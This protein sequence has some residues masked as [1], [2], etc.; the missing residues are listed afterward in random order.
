MIVA[1]GL[2]ISGVMKRALPTATT[3]TSAWRVWRSRSRVSMWQTVGVAKRCN[4]ICSS[5]RPTIELA[6]TS[7]TSAPLSVTPSRSS[8]LITP[9]AVQGDI[10]LGSE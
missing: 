1:P 5:G 3:S 8:R 10:T 9:V 6:P 4:I 2:I 7:V